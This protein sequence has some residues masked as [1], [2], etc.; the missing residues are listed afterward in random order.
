MDALL[1]VSPHC[2][3]AVL[4]CGE[5]IAASGGATVVTVFAGAPSTYEPLTVW[6]L[7]AGFLPGDDVMAAR[8]AEDA[9][10]LSAL[11]ARP[12]WMDFRDAQYGPSPK[13]Q[14]LRSALASVIE[15]ERP[16]VVAV[17]LGLFHGDH[18]LVHEACM[19]LLG[20]AP[21]LDWLAYE[22]AMY[23]A[24]PGLVDDRLATLDAAGIVA[25]PV[26]PLA[27]RH[28]EVKRRA[29]AHYRSQLRALSEVAAGYADAF[30]PERYWRVHRR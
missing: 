26:A 13:V 9:A 20:M 21:T 4:S 22:D 14:E 24:I 17:P 15:T 1:V 11:G 18:E 3:D 8:R 28:V 5:L 10:A 2:D 12:H 19:Q 23:R 6:D 25:A 29:A 30:E 7:A 16:F 27:T